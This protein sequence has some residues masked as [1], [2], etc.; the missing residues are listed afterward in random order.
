LPAPSGISLGSFRV[1]SD[2]Y[3]NS[4]GTFNSAITMNS[5]LL[6]EGVNVKDKEGRNH[7]NLGRNTINYLVNTS[8]SQASICSRKY[9]LINAHRR[10]IWKRENNRGQVEGI[11][12]FLHFLQENIEG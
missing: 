9:K 5:D 2:F 8:L 12:I 1:A 11:K 7:K 6:L 10:L 3:F 4:T